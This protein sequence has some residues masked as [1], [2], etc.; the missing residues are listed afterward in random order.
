MSD[1]LKRYPPTPRR[2]QK[3]REAGLSPASSAVTAVAM[4]LVVT[5]A[6]LALG[7][8]LVHGLTRLLA[9]DLQRAVRPA[10]LA[11][12]DLRLLLAGRFAVAGLIVVAAGAIVAAALL[13]AQ[14]LQGQVRQHSSKQMYLPMMTRVGRSRG[15]ARPAFPVLPALV[16]VCAAVAMIAAW[17]RRLA[18]A[19][20]WPGPEQLPQVGPVWWRW[21]AALGAV[22][23]LHAAGTWLRHMSQAQ[24]TRRE[25][26]EE[27]RETEG[28]RKATVR[29]RPGGPRQV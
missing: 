22:A 12:T 17:V 24:M 26:L 19:E 25:L 8:M 7:P 13:L 29:R 4:L 11:A 20:S 14:A 1:D 27:L 16:G 9:D 6:G 28:P 5:L 21:L 2:L 15:R 10:A 23:V 3:L 18:E